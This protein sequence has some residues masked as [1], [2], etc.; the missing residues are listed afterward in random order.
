MNSKSRRFAEA[1]KL[2]AEEAR[3][4]PA[5]PGD[6]LGNVSLTKEEAADPKRLDQEAERY[7]LAFDKEEDTD[8][9]HIG[10]ADFDTNRAFV[11]TIEAARA[12]ASGCDGDALALRLLKMAIREVE[13]ATALPARRAVI[14]RAAEAM[15]AP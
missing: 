6:G 8:H 12:L 9:F 3:Y 10:C 4:R 13:S 2:M 5:A 14:E 11:F 1:Y 15:E 7:A